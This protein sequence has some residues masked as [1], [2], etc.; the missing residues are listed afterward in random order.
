MIVPEEPKEPEV[1]VVAKEV[2]PEVSEEIHVNVNEYNDLDVS[3]AHRKQPRSC[4]L[5]PI[6]K[7]MSY[8]A[9]SSGY[10]SFV[11]GLD[12]VHIHKNIQEAL[13][14]PELMRSS[15]NTNQLQMIL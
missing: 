13:E 9:L 2:V 12:K 15:K 4:T 10:R 8:T 1:V 14:V 3:I 5:H 7:Y 6:Q 11:T